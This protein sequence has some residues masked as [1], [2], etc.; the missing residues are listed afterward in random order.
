MLR[1]KLSAPSMAQLWLLVALSAVAWSFGP[2]CVRYAFAYE[3]PPQLVAFGRLLMG[4]LAFTPYMLY[5]GSRQLRALPPKTLSLALAAGILQG[6][7]VTLMIS[8]LQ[9]ISIVINQSLLNTIPLWVAVFEVTLLKTRLSAKVWL[10][11][12]VAVVGGTL[13]AIATSDAPAS[14]PGGNTSL[15]L[16][17]AAVSACS[18]SLYV[19]IGRKARG[20]MPFIPYIWLVYCAGAAVTFGIIAASDIS[21]IGYDP[22]GYLWVLLL[23]V[24]AQI[25]GLGAFNFTLKFM[26]PTTLTMTMQAMPIM[27]ACWAF[28][29]F[30]EVPTA[31]QALG[32]VIL[33][34]GV[35]I[36]LWGQ[37]QPR[38]ARG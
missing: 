23:A 10:G 31:W 7:N 21:L 22:R 13:I 5:R 26:S 6:I 33:L 37:S 11:I 36:V 9:H 17:L 20:S 16:L 29:I 38:R 35:T 28:L 19:I 8:S 18:A 34:L 12:A 32:S 25:I 4:M 2:I 15:G 30:S 24:L 27:S 14:I 3:L 1:L